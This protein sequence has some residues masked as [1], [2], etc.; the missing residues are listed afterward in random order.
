MKLLILPHAGGSARGYCVFKKFLAN[1]IELIPAEPAGRGS[2]TAEACFD[3]ITECATDLLGRN[4]EHIENGD[5]AVFGHSMGTLLAFEF[6]RLAV[7][8]GLPAPKHVFL[9][10]RCAPDEAPG[11]FSEEDDISD[12]DVVDVFIKNKL[13]PDMILENKEMLNMISKIIGADVRMVEKYRPTPETFK[14]PCDVS[15]L[16]GT[17]DELLSGAGVD[18]WKRFAQKN[19]DIH[20]FSGGHFYYNDNKEAVCE[21]ISGKLL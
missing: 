14:F 5:Y 15:V 12:S 18:G 8:D 9:S 2:R 3:D 4:R 10:G 11:L 20:S 13:L 16:Y 19:C 7:K 1:G 6:V 21:L 17:E